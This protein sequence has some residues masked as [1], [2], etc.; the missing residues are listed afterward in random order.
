MTIPAS[1]YY[2]AEIDT[3]GNL[4]VVHDALRMT[5]SEDYNPGD[6]T[7]HLDGDPNI[8]A[9]WPA[10]GLI[11]LTEQCSDLDKRAISFYYT[12]IDHNFLTLSGLQL[13]PGFP[14]VVKPKSITHVTENV[15]AQHHN[16]IKDA[17]LAIQNFIGIQGTIDPK[18]LG[19]TMEGRINFLRKLV[20]TPKAYFSVDRTIG[21][22]PFTVNFKN[23]SFRLGSDGTTGEIKFVWDFGDE[24]GN[25]TSTSVISNVSYTSVNDLNVLEDDFD[26]ASLFTDV[27]VQKT[28]S[29]PGIYS[30]KLTVSNAFGSDTIV[31]PDLINARVP[32]PLAATVNYTVGPT[33]NLLF[34]GSP[35]GGPYTN[36]PVVRTPTNTLLTLSVPDG[37]NPSNPGYTYAGEKLTNGGV[38]IDPATSFT[39]H[40]GDDLDHSTNSQATKASWSVGGLY[41]MKLRIDTA[42][43]AYRITSY[44]KSINVIENTNLWLWAFTSANNVTP[45]EFGLFSQTFKAA[46]TASYSVNRDS[47]FLA[48]QGNAIQLVPEFNRNV[49]G[50]PRS[51]TSSGAGGDYLL[52]YA[53]GRT[54]SASASTET[55]NTVGFNGFTS[56]YDTTTTGFPRPWNWASFTLAQNS[57]FLFGEKPTTPAPNTSPTNPI[58]DTMSLLTLAT[59]QTTLGNSN[60]QNGGEELLNNPALFDGAGNSLYGHFTAY[61][62]ASKGSTGFIA[63]NDGV[64]QFF[65]IKN[66]YQTSGTVGTPVQ[67]IS[68]LIDIPGSTKLEGEMVGLTGGVYFFNNSGSISAYNDTTGIWETGGPGTN[69]ASFR[70][71]QDTTVTDFDNPRN[72]LLAAGDGDKRVYLSYEYSNQAFIMFNSGELAFTSLGVRPVGSQWTMAIY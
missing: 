31:W 2:P 65:R 48:S 45:Y 23:L 1:T 19:P 54:G 57:F 10:T 29:T 39:W 71:F 69:T 62:T 25:T 35:S 34:P 64:G 32:A 61:R 59:T 41:D 11:T 68:K 5:L 58:M 24:S 50:A 55:V 56:T 3:D 53:S 14:D 52:Y 66:F 9:R 8:L 33:Q 6:T 40:L 16:H 20:L 60:F 7:I 63:R 13:L 43:G 18:P 12:E 17:V 51:T 26:N 70:S 15:M 21:L 27:V 67:F 47:S 30:V 22:V 38:P 36:P 72:P 49:G 42:Y 44:P 28:Y 46:G 37:Q 4:F